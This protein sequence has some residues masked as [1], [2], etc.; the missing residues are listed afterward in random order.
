MKIVIVSGGFDPLHSGH[1]AYFKSS[2]KLGDKLIVALNSDEWLINKK[3]KFFMPFHER[4]SIVENLSCVDL[5]VDFED[6]ELGSAS[7]ALIKIQEMYPDDEL[8]FAN[9]GDRNKENIPEMSV[10]KIRFEFSVGGDDKKNSSSWILKNWQYYHEE[11]IW[12][13]F[14][15]LFEE[16]QVKVKELIVAPGKGMSFQKHFKRSEIWMVS[17]GSCIVNFSK[18]HPENK[19]SIELN[20]FDH[21]LVP[22]GEWHQITNPFD[23]TCHIIEIQYGEECVEDDIERTEYYLPK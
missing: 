18:G 5:I 14:Y 3:G 22:V 8:I 2:K 16:N 7:N 4:K 1:I 9:G 11:R 12:G 21:Y 15:N 6:D 17:K 20:K 13:S 23:N 19:E 10:D